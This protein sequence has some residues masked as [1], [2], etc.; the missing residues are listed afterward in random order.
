V[1]Y[2][3]P[4]AL[5]SCLDSPNTLIGG[6]AV[7]LDGTAL[8]L[9]LRPAGALACAVAVVGELALAAPMELGLAAE[10]AVADAIYQAVPTGGEREREALCRSA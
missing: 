2:I 8:V 7:S 9:V 10:T 6:F 3:H 5:F 4:S 1:G